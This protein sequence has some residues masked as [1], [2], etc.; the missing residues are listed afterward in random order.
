M[1]EQKT[2]YPWDG[3]VA[4]TMRS[5]KAAEFT[6]HVRVPGWSRASSIAVNGTRERAAA[7]PGEY[8]A[9]RRRW[10]TGDRVELS[11]DMRVQAIAANPRLAENNGRVAIRR[12]PLVYCL[13]GLDQLELGSIFDAAL[14]LSPEPWRAFRP[15]RRHDLL[16]GIVILKHTG[17]TPVR[18]AE[19]EPLYQ[20]VEAARKR[21]M[22]PA[23][24]TL[25]PYFA[26]ANRE[27]TPMRVWI[28]FQPGE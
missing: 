18:P 26:F 11:L 5:E 24:L 15:E 23:E 28:P 10:Q 25:I 20:S 13:E 27:D 9:I 22:R 12:G 16:G 3:S 21:A 8:F 4:I 17:A 1:L 6:L 19:H 7:R 14:V 2:D